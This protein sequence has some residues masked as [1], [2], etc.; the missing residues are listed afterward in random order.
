[1]NSTGDYLLARAKE[2]STWRGIVLIATA[3]GATIEPVAQEAI[4]VGGLFIAGL[5][6]AT[7]PDAKSG[8]RPADRR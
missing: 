8:P 1:V 2:P 6:G 3:G 7:M 4:V 5:I